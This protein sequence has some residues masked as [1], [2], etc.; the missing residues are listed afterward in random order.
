MQQESRPT[1]W[2][3]LDPEQ[4]RDELEIPPTGLTE[5]QASQRLQQY[6]PNRLPAPAGRSLWSRL[7]GQFNNVL[8]Y[9]LMTAVL[10][11]ALLR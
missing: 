3:A 8:I 9:V 6:G 1:P 11:T 5:A 2:H 4:V 7:L 10:V